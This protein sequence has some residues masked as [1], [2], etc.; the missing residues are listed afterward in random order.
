MADRPGISR[1]M[2]RATGRGAVAAGRGAAIGGTAAMNN[3]WQLNKA[4]VGSNAAGMAARASGKAAGMF[5]KAAMTIPGG[6]A[7]LG[8]PFAAMS[9]DST[10]NS[11]GSHM[12][13]ETMK[14]GAD[15]AFDMALF[16]TVGRAGPYGMAAA[17]IGS[18][19][20]HMTGTN[21]GAIVGNMMDN[22]GKSYRKSLGLGATPITQNQRTMRSQQQGMNLIGQSRGAGSP[23]HS[24]LGS[25]AQY[26]H[27]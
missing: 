8:L 9:H 15:A 17:L 4:M 14:I 21:P 23:G 18:V 12:A 13:Q 16:G 27:N 26:M 1:R 10:K 2:L 22:A 11:F 6:Y 25:E 20:M 3:A 19:A 7:L 5:G 24:M